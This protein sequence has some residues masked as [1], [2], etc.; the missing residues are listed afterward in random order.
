MMPAARIDPSCP[1]CEGRG[2]ILAADGGAGAAAPCPCR[3][4][5]AADVRLEKA[6][7]P[8]R[9]RA[10][11]LDNFNVDQPTGADRL[12]EA[13]E[14]SRRY[15]E[16]FVSPAG[17]IRKT[18]LLFVGPPGGGKTHLAVGVLKALIQ[19]Y[20]V[21]GRFVDFT[22]LVHQIQA[23]F[24]PGSE[25]SKR[26]VLDPVIDAQVL[27]LDELGAQRA[28]PFVND[29]LYLVLNT[30]YTRCLPT[31]FTTNYPLAEERRRPLSLDRGGAPP[32]DVLASRIPAR[33]VSRLYE[34]VQMID[35]PVSDFRREV[36][37]AQTHI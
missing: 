11:T 17:K 8:E 13:R 31:L 25:E 1:R 30:R 18:G 22:S 24:D 19:R 36:K 10:T 4:A 5:N 23:T 33:L 28:T 2:W 26:Q 3:T 9:Y 16:T 35:L 32:V 37:M 27:V 21:R 15:V 29:I 20:A 14:L 6:G 12:L 34:M 7:I